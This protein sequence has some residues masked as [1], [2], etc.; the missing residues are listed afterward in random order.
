MIIFT[1]ALT[2]K[3]YAFTSRPWELR[4][5]QSIDI[6]D[7]LGSNIRIDFKEAEILRILPRRNFDIN[8]S[9]ISDKV[10]FFYD[11]L[12]RQRLTSPYIKKNGELKK[13]KWKTFLSKYSS[14]LKVFSFEFGSS[15]IGLLV[16]SNMD[17]ETL[18][19]VRQF[20]SNFGFSC[21]GMDLIFDNPNI[22]KFQLPIKNL[23]EIDYCL[24]LGT[25]PRFEASVLNV[26][27][28]KLYR[29]GNVH[30]DSI[31][32]TYPT[33]F[34]VRS[35]GLTST[36]L[37]DLAEGKHP[38]CKNL[39]KSKKP[40]IVYGSSLL[41]RFDAV[42]ILNLL[43]LMQVN[44][45]VVFGSFFYLNPLHNDSN[46]VG[47]FELAVKSVRSDSFN[48][49]KLLYCVGSDTNTVLSNLSAKPLLVWQ[50]SHGNSATNQYDLILP[51]TTFV[52]KTGVYYNTEGRPQKTQKA[53]SGPLLARDNWKIFQVLGFLMEKN[54]GF[55]TRS[56]LITE[57][58]KIL[59]SAFFADAWF[60]NREKTLSFFFGLNKE[61]KEKIT[62]SYF[63][64]LIED[65][66]MTNIYCNSSRIMAKA[67]ESLRSYTTNYKFL[68]FIS[69]KK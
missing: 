66:Y 39:A 18:F 11:G 65:F 13:V 28:R 57:C 63:K 59:P 16:G 32:G 33:T 47:S 21:F 49:L 67:S 22:Y 4:S 40:V 17:I 41:K 55:T 36:T 61:K 31:G 15:R 58:S 69:Y 6:L 60:S 53:L 38:I 52:E 1:G 35:W 25:N 26:R 23:E 45:H 24:F 2:S 5:V 48:N 7:G 56:Q 68:N 50:T 3:P 44:Y 12:K 9:W 30:F 37:I 19:S 43:S 27:F 62:K 51:T 29:R 14:L 42:G 20:S 34:P 10:R 8:E 46:S 54:I 64:L